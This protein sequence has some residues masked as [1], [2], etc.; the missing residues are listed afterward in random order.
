MIRK[1]AGNSSLIRLLLHKNIQVNYP[2]LH[3]RRYI[4]KIHPDNQFKLLACNKP[5]KTTTYS[6]SFFYD[7]N[8]QEITP[9]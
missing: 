7:Y 5:K 8:G 1:P 2:Q 4:S 6:C 9:I 3:N